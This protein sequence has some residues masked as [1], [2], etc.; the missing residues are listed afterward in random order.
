MPESTPK[1]SPLPLAA[2][3]LQILLVLAEGDLYGYAIKK[4]VHSQSAG[5]LDPEIGSLYRVLARL[6][7]CEWVE[8]AP[9]PEGAPVSGHGRPRRYYR[10][11]PNGRAVAREEVDRLRT[12]VDGADRLALK[13][14]P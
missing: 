13:G 12:L 10:I 8:E 3:D 5:V 14:T 2:L 11:T 4:A 6:A 9:P 1:A 7:G